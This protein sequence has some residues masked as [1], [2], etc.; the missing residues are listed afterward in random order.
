MDSSKRFVI[1]EATRKRCNIIKIEPSKRRMFRPISL[2]LFHF[3][4]EVEKIDFSIF[5]QVEDEFI[6]YIRPKELSQELLTHIWKA[7]QKDSGNVKVCVLTKDINKFE[8][9]IDQVRSKKI[10]SLLEKEPS[11]DRQ[12]LEVFNDLSGASQ[13]VLRG[14]INKHVASRVTAAASYMMSHLMNN[15]YAMATLSK[16]ILIDPTLYDHSAAVAMFA[17]IMGKQQLGKK[18][19]GSHLQ[20]ITQ[21]GLYHDAGKSC[22]ANSILNKPGSF[23]DEEYE[24]MKTHVNFG[25][26]ELM[27]AIENGAPIDKIVA[28]VALE[29][30]ERFKG[31]GYPYQKKGRFEDDPENGIHLYSRIVAIADAYSALLMKRVYKPAIPSNQA[32]EMLSKN[33]HQ[34][35]DLEIFETFINSIRKSY[36]SLDVKKK[37]IEKGRI[38]M[39]DRNQSLMHQMKKKKE[40]TR[41]TG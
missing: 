21:C 11:L 39:V 1:K 36:H 2:E 15:D 30:H 16:M 41:K 6:E 12:T 35:F 31:N 10:D 9:A 33:A 27:S 25:H 13:M 23:T 38:F 14:G 18:I 34:H 26:D 40:V 5:I 4:Q 28:R 24:I 3:L 29:H 17:G 22:I 7:T 19:D 20:L 8:F 37:E 32:I